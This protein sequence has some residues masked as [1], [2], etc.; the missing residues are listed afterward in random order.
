LDA[1]AGEVAGRI[2]DADL[3]AV[4]VAAARAAEAERVGSLD[5][6]GGDECGNDEKRPCDGG[7]HGARS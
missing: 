7:I 1:R 6:R 4:D 3:H 5:R 2:V